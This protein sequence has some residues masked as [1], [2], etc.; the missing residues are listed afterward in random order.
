MKHSHHFSADTEG[1]LDLRLTLVWIAAAL[2]VGAAANVIA[3]W[4]EAGL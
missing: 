3:A 4:F 1:A 2:A